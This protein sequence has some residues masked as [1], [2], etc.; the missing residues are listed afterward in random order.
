MSTQR[1]ELRLDTDLERA[2]ADVQKLTGLSKSHVIQLAVRV[3]LPDLGKL[4]GV[5][6]VITKPA[7][8]GKIP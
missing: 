2:V 1:F 8:S 3:G 7:I 6:V 5:D 4:L